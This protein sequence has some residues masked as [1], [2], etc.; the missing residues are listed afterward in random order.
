MLSEEM[1]I[2]VRKLNIG[3]VL[4]TINKIKDSSGNVINSCIGKC[5]GEVKSID[6][7]GTVFIYNGLSKES[8]SYNFI[9][10]NKKIIAGEYTLLKKYL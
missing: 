10:I 5:I 7:N 2:K 1:L 6:A 8:V 3:K 9:E 4:Y